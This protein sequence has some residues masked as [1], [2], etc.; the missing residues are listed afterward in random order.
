MKIKMTSIISLLLAI[1]IG[2]SC[3]GC[4]YEIKSEDL[5][6]GY[7]RKSKDRVN[8]EPVALPAADNSSMT[9]FAV[10]LFKASLEEGK[11][12]LISPLSVISA[13][14]MTAGGADG[15]TLVQMEKVFGMDR[16]TLDQYLS[17]YIGGLPQGE[18][19]KLD[20][21][22]SI[23]IN[24]RGNFAPNGDFLQ[25]NADY[26]GAD[27][28][29]SEFD[30][31]TLRDINNWV[32][33]KTDGMIDSI[34]DKIPAE[35]IMYLINAL[36]FDSDW[37]EQY[38]KYQVREG[39]FTK[40]DGSRLNVDFM[41]SGE[42][43]YIE[44]ELAVGFIKYYVGREYAFVALLPNEGVSID[45]YI[46]SLDGERLNKMLTSPTPATINASIPKFETKYSV[47]MS[48]I[49]SELGMTNAFDSTLS[50]FSKM[51]TADGN[52][53]VNRVLHKTFISVGEKGTR[54]G[55]VT[56]VEVNCESAMMP[57]EEPKVIYL[58]RPFVYMLIDCENGIP[59]F[60]GAMMDP[61]K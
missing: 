28:Y 60:I 38:D 11:N 13:L 23:W 56:A 35:A 6:Y 8:E 17:S 4:A 45:E 40:A 7:E 57:I 52:I 33:D 25:H 12:T 39:V 53:Y 19:Y 26:Y 50:D 21:A 31:T 46:N 34:L 58:D 24:N 42:S 3:V 36:A 5:M 54:A 27:I 47:E 18:K 20:L 10:K 16:D 51:G 41:Y 1:L 22:N 2:I 15:E 9:E 59:F 55:A 44:D 32:K 30:D 29:E 37:E 61:T 14:A 49:L 43:D 48:E